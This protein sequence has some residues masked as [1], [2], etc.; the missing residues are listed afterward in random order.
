M[1]HRRLNRIYIWGPCT[2][3]GNWGVSRIFV[4]HFYKTVF[5]VFVYLKA[6]RD[7]CAVEPHLL[8]IFSNSAKSP[9]WRVRPL[10]SHI[11]LLLLPC[12][13]RWYL[14]VDV[15]TTICGSSSLGVVKYSC[16]HK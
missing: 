3:F 8:N 16:T 1:E 7:K 5:R 2:E 9:R 15:G 10:R 4:M 12:Q 11:F 14:D 13:E 6:G